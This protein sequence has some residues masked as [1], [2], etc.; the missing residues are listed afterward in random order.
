MLCVG[1]PFIAAIKNILT[2]TIYARNRHSE[3]TRAIPPMIRNRWQSPQKQEDARIDAVKSFTLPEGLVRMVAEYSVGWAAEYYRGNMTAKEVV[4]FAWS[5]SPRRKCGPNLSQ[6]TS[7][8]LSEPVPSC[9]IRDSGRAGC[10]R[11]PNAAS[12]SV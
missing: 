5:N 4:S 11:L 8:E 12:S 3:G 9:A 10:G 2:T 1:L 7:L 6:A